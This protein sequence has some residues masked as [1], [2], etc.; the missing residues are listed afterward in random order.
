M[1]PS[2]NVIDFTSLSAPLPPQMEMRLRLL[3]I[4][5]DLAPRLT[6]GAKAEDVVARARVLE[7]YV[8]GSPPGSEAQAPSGPA[9]PGTG[10]PVTAPDAGPADLRHDGPEIGGERQQPST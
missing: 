4:A 7:L 3:R 8:A 5:A 9:E 1:E 10:A 6:G 2:V